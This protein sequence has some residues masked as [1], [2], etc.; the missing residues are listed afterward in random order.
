MD[1]DFSIEL[2]R[3]DPVLD[4]PWT[5]PDGKLAYFDL[6]RHPE[7]LARV[8]EAKQFPELEDFLRAVN[9]AMSSV[10]SAKCDAWF[11]EELRP[12]EEI[13]GASCKCAS[14]AD[15]VFSSIDHRQSFPFHELFAKRLVELLRRTPETPSS[16][17]L[18]VR[19]CY[20]HS[21]AEPGEGFYITMYV[22]GYGDD[23]ARA[24]Q[25]WEIGL[26]LVGN[27]VLQLSAAG[28]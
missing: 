14:Y 13:F 11:T 12:E 7:L 9:S 19:R 20:F 23:Q 18:S 21:E 28:L 3:E 22:S 26:K 15:L 27:A 5:D 6:K 8:E 17:E 4:F 24:R 25:N 1:A 16:A 10:E 2:G